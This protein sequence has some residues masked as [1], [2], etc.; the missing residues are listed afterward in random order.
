MQ[1]IQIDFKEWEQ[2][3]ATIGSD[4][5]FYSN[6]YHLAACLLLDK[7]QISEWIRSKLVRMTSLIWNF[8]SLLVLT[9]TI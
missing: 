5:V 2:N 1:P 3:V 9:M 8:S 6:P 4:P 7:N